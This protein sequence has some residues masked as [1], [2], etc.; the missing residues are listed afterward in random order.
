VDVHPEAT[1]TEVPGG[2][3]VHLSRLDDEG[4]VAHDPHVCIEF[5]DALRLAVRHF[6]RLSKKR[7]RD[8]IDAVI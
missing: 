4:D 3:I 2:Y 5:E 1:I 7:E 6:K 8:L